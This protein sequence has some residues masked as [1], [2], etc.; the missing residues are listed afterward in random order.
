MAG[1]IPG[2]QPEPAT[3]NTLTRAALAYLDPCESDPE[4]IQDTAWALAEAG[5]LRDCLR[6]W[7]DSLGMV[8]TQEPEPLSA[9]P[10]AVF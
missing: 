7:L 1:S 3:L 2:W 8:E 9:E 5:P 6:H 4:P 10:K